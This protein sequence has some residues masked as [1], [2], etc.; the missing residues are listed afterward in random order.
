MT[1]KK[2]RETSSSQL[3]RRRKT[4]RAKDQA[5]YA[6]RREELIAHAAEVFS[7]EGYDRTTLSD[8][9]ERAGTDRA[10]VYYYVSSKEELFQEVCS[11]MLEQNL[12]AAEE[13]AMRDNAPREKL[14]LIIAHH[15]STHE[16]GFPQWSVLVQEMRRITGADTT[17]TRDAVEKMRRY[18]AIVRSILE[19]GIA[20]G[21]IRA[22]VPSR[23]AMNAIFG[24]LNWTH[25][26]FRPDGQYNAAQV[27]A[28]FAAI[29]LDGLSKDTE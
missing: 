23:L 13:I 5:A 2:R 10:S 9:A 26:W 4:A 19:D 6:A 18:E 21:T 28:A 7:K 3:G 20:D 12:A 16:R 1:D 11:G 29:T 27:A 24:M 25:R 15:M 14:E 22:D 17:W 8:I